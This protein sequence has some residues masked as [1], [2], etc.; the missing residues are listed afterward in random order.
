VPLHLILNFRL[1]L[2]TK[3]SLQPHYWTLSRPRDIFSYFDSCRLFT[4][5]SES[6][7][8]PTP[9]VEDITFSRNVG[10]IDPCFVNLIFTVFKHYEEHGFVKI[11]FALCRLQS[12]G[13]LWL[14]LCEAVGS[15]GVFPPR[16]RWYRFGSRRVRVMGHTDPLLLSNYKKSHMS[17]FVYCQDRPLDRI[18]RKEGNSVLPLSFVQYSVGCNVLCIHIEWPRKI[19]E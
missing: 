2:Q 19:H 14:S 7:A 1:R 10:N 6:W 12:I 15:W 3:L 16:D 5:F 9:E 13:L 17:L 11:V 8:Q 18:F 4:D